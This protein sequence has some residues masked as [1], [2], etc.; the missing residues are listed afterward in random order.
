MEENQRGTAALRRALAR[1]R[2]EPATAVHGPNR[3][4]GRDLVV[5]DIH[6]HFP[7]LA[8]ALDA[9]DFDAEADR[10]FSVGD[11]TSPDRNR[12]ASPVKICRMAPGSVKKTIG[13]RPSRRTVN[14]SPYRSA[15]ARMN[16]SGAK[17]HLSS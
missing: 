8:R 6:G 17:V 3:R 1:A 9:L 12:S 4:G 10:L 11:L 13:G 2:P 7:T 15:Q 16:G 5:G 14:V